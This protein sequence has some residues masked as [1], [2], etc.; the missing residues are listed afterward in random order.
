M[1]KLFRGFGALLTRIGQEV[2]VLERDEIEAILFHRGRMLLLDRVILGN[3]TV[4]GQLTITPELCEGHEPTPGNPV[5]RGVDIV[6]MAFQLLGILMAKIPGLAD[7]LENKALAAREI[8]GAKFTGFV[9]PGD[10]L[11]LETPTD[12]EVDEA[13]G[14]ARF[15]SSKMTATVNGKRK[16][17]V[18]SVSIAGFSPG[19]LQKK[20]QEVSES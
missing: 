4:Q 7:S 19:L 15:E 1:K 17:V 6:E 20:S 9:V 16:A 13:A 2:V 5:F 14:F 3:D 18:L 12:V 11:C 10:V 8:V